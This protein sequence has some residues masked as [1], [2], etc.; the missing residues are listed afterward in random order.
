MMMEE[1]GKV[2][3]IVVEM[4]VHVP[5]VLFCSF[6]FSF[7]VLSY[8]YLLRIICYFVNGFFLLLSFQISLIKVKIKMLVLLS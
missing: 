7:S 6:S 4:F 5:L 1:R 2:M 3:E 8:Y